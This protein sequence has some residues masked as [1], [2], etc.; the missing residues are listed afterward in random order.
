MKSLLLPC[1]LAL[2]I[3][4]ALGWLAAPELGPSAATASSSAAAPASAEAPPPEAPDPA[5][6][7]EL[8]RARE[9]ARTSETVGADAKDAPEHELREPVVEGGELFSARLREH[10]EAG[11]REGWGR[12]R[13]DSIPDVLLVEGVEQYRRL[14]EEAPAAMGFQLA[15]KEDELDEAREVGEA[16]ELLEK[17]EQ[18]QGPLPEVAADAKAFEQLFRPSTPAVVRDGPGFS[19]DGAPLTEDGATLRFPAG[20]FRVRDLVHSSQPMPR[21][22]TLVG[23]GKDATL[24]LFDDLSCRGRLANFGIENCTVLVQD[25]LFD[26]R[27]EAGVIRLEHVRILGHDRSAGGTHLMSAPSAA[28]LAKDCEFLGG[29]GGRPGSSSIFDVRRGLVARFDR[30][31]FVELEL[32]LG[33]LDGKA[34]VVFSRCDFV[35]SLEDV[36][37]QAA[38][39]PGVQLEGCSIRLYDK[40]APDAWPPPRRDLNELFPGWR[41]KIQ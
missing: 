5:A 11:I 28:F 27:G 25:A 21:D 34:T 38:K 13:P 9:A 37:A 24:L 26:L 18:G 12:V 41:E 39:K 20:V 15:R 4:L 2:T 32:G 8:P 22:V 35:D 29:Y 6:T 17:L 30:C 10:A 16:F 3:G 7:G 19:R 40:G 23:A 36:R 31:R 14:V 1:A 33:S